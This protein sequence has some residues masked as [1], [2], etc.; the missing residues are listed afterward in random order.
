MA[1]VL[2]LSRQSG[3]RLEDAKRFIAEY[4]ER[5]AGVRAY[6]DRQVE[7]ARSRWLASRRCSSGGA[8]SLRSRTRTS[9]PGLRRALE[10]EL[11]LQGSAADL[12]KIAMVRLTTRSPPNGST[13]AAAPGARRARA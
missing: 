4:F 12:I 3:F 6:L 13:A 2:A 7:L 11:A 10:P 1:K 5:F 9:T 8:T